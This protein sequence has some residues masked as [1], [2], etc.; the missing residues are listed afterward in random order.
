[1]FLLKKS[2]CYAYIYAVIILQIILESLPISSSGHLKLLEII[3][4]KFDIFFYF[5]LQNFGLNYEILHLPS[6]LVIFIFFFQDFIEIILITFK[7][8]RNFLQV[9]AFIF[10]TNSITILFY[11]FHKFK[12]LPEI[13]LSLGFFITGIILFS[14]LFLIPRSRTQFGMTAR[15]GIPLRYYFELISGSN[16]FKNAFILGIAQG[17]ALFSG[18]SRFAIVFTTSRY[19]GYSPMQSFFVTFFIELPL[20]VAGVLKGFVCLYWEHNLANL[21]NLDFLMCL[22]FILAT[23]ISYECLGIMK[24]IIEKNRIWMLSFYMLIPALISF[25]LGN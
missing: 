3:N 12:I 24:K 2:F 7:S 13:P 23:I 19:L 22:T 6:I 4:Q 16:E 17:T 11:L 10:I 25:L 14:L 15:R 20:L 5:P 21:S 1:M 8:L 9:F 18:I